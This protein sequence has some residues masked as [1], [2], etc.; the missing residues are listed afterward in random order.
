LQLPLFLDML[1]A[2]LQ[3]IDLQRLATDL[4]FQLGDPALLLPPLAIACECLGTVIAQLAPPA[5]QDIRVH[6][7][8]S[9][10]FGDPAAQ[11]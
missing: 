7:A 3:K 5:V 10:H 11:L 1:Q 4:T 8:G 6:L 2:P 9:R